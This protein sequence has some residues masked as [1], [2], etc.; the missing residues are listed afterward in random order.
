[1]S[2]SDK[3]DEP[4]PVRLEYF[5]GR[6]SDEPLPGHMI[7][8]WIVL[9]MAWLPFACGVINRQ[10]VVRSGV[11]SIVRVHVNTGI[12]LMIVGAI[13]S[14]TCGVAFIG[15]RNV[16]SAMVALITF[17]LQVFLFFCIGGW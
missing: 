17:A 11:E 8:W 7:F 15:H 14:A 16:A 1:M 13:L 10:A 12:V 2:Q 5:A 3:P 9:V 4:R 6:A